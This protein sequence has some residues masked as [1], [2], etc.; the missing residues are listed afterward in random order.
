VITDP[1]HRDTV[2]TCSLAPQLNEDIFA[3]AVPQEARDLWEWLCGQ[4]FRQRPR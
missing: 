4:P 2:L 3:A 1:R